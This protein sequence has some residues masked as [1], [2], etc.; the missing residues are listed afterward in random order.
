M[1]FERL[2]I[3]VLPRGL[4]SQ[5]LLAAH[6]HVVAVFHLAAFFVNADNQ[7][8]HCGRDLLYRCERRVRFQIEE[9]LKKF[10]ILARVLQILHPSRERFR[11]QSILLFHS[12]RNLPGR[13]QIAG[14]L[15][16]EGFTQLGRAFL[17]KGVQIVFS[18]FDPL[19]MR[20]VFLHCSAIGKR[21]LINFT[22]S[23]HAL[24]RVEVLRGNRI[25]LVIMA[26][27]AGGG[28][29]DKDTGGRVHA[30][31]A[32]WAQSM[33]SKGGAQLVVIRSGYHVTR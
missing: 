6:L 23:E 21:M 9:G 30:I 16:R 3:G 19:L 2:E 4:I 1:N 28:D 27:R 10:M 12:M 15:A 29:A 24:Q 26:L 13:G 8:L 20:G 31:V 11:I 25:E 33:K 7:Y 32:L 22:A 5:A 14:G 17:N 18:V